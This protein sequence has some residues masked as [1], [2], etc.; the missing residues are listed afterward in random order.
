MYDLQFRKFELGRG[1]VAAICLT[2]AWFSARFAKAANW[3]TRP[4]KVEHTG[5]VSVLH[6]Y[7]THLLF[8]C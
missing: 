5:G 7:S 8:L 4:T 1:R 6:L 2:D 3:H